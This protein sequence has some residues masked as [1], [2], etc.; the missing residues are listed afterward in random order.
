MSGAY[1]H[2]GAHRR[3]QLRRVDGFVGADLR[4]SVRL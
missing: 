3:Q 4:L 2:L 1:A